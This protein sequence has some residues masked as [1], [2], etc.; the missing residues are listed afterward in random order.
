MVL[1]HV[2]ILALFGPEKFM[3]SFFEYLFNFCKAQVHV[4]SEVCSRSG[5]AGPRTEDKDLDLGYTLNC[6]AQIQAQ[7][8]GQVQKVQG[9]G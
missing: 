2:S 9:L 3:I 5:P 7:I 4:R 8:P 1:K 6:Q